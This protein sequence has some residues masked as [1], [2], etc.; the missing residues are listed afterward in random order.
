MGKLT[1]E[2]IC[3]VPILVEELGISGVARK[4]DVSPPA[5]RYVIDHQLWKQYSNEIGHPDRCPD[6]GGLVLNDM[7]PCP[8]CST[9]LFEKNKKQLKSSR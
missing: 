6:C 4:F 5:I 3:Q 8:L 9:R 7:E 1:Q 2:Q